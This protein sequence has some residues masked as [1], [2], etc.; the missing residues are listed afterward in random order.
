[1]LLKCS[2]RIDGG[3]AAWHSLQMTSDKQRFLDGCEQAGCHAFQVRTLS[4]SN[5]IIGMILPTVSSLLPDQAI[6]MAVP[7]RNQSRTP[8]IVHQESVIAD[9]VGQG[10]EWRRYRAGKRY[11]PKS[12]YA[13][14]KARELTQLLLIGR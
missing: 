14:A 11:L 2:R 1:M 7:G 13:L 5:S 4:S 10:C 12:R 9:S 6:T 3:E 8:V